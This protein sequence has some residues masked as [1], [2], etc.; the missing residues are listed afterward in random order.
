MKKTVSLI[1]ENCLQVSEMLLELQK[2]ENLVEDLTQVQL[3]QLTKDTLDLEALICSK[4]YEVATLQECLS[5]LGSVSDQ[6]QEKME[7]LESKKNKEIGCLK[8]A[9]RICQK[10][11]Q[12]R[13]ADLVRL[14]EVD[15]NVQV[16]KQTNDLLE[17]ELQV[18]EE[19]S[20]KLEEI[21]SQLEESMLEN[22]DL[23]EELD[24]QVTEN[25]KLVN[26]ESQLEGTLHDVELEVATKFADLHQLKEVQNDLEKSFRENTKLQEELDVAQVKIEKLSLVQ[27]EFDLCIDQKDELQERFDKNQVEVERLHEVIHRFEISV[28]QVAALQ[29]ELENKMADIREL[30]MSLG[31]SRMQASELQEHLDAALNEYEELEVLHSEKCEVLAAIKEKVYAETQGKV[32]SP[33]SRKENVVERMEEMLDMISDLKNNEYC[34][35]QEISRKD[36][37]IQDLDC[38]LHEELSAKDRDIEDLHKTETQLQLQ[39]ADKNTTIECLGVT[40]AKLRQSNETAIALAKSLCHKNREIKRLKHT[41][42]DLERSSETISV[43]EMELKT[44]ET[45]VKDLKSLYRKEREENMSEKERHC[46]DVKHLV[47]ELESQ[48]QELVLRNNAVEVSTP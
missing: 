28:T 22:V 18:K 20:A 15:H 44:R 41:V 1:E 24:L 45:E 9:L 32:H 26:I 3:K 21:Q 8:A 31:K 29:A 4:N 23:L 10:E 39:L 43:L 16:C 27:S 2:E 17:A 11:L 12:V 13:A 37:E 33:D 38:S 34:L 6:Y 14:S 46:E 30:K 5:E 7:G 25:E 42:D 35:K 40:E 47:A 36:V 48:G 19:E